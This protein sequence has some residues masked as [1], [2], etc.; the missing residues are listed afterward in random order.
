M[1]RPTPAWLLPV[2]R[3]LV[4]IAA[5]AVIAAGV[6]Y[7]RPP[8]DLTIEVGAV[9]GSYYDNAVQYRD[10]LAR[11]GINLHIVSNN[12]TLDIVKDVADPAVPI[13]VGFIAE[14]VTALRGADVSTLSIV[15]LQPLFVF[16][17]AELGRRTILDDLRGR[18]IV[19]LPIG[20]ATANAALRVFQLLDVTQENTSFT[21]LPLA[22]AVRELRAGK[23]DAGAFMLSPD[24]KLIREMAADSGLTLMPF[25]EVRAIANQL[26]F[27]RPVVLPR[28]IYN[29]ADG[30]P[31][32]DT[33]LLAAS[34]GLVAHNG[35]H[36]WI[37]YSLLDAVGKTHRG[38]TLVSEAGDFPT[39]S[40]SQLEVDP[41]AVQWYKN[42]LPWVWR[43]LP[44]EVASFV[45]RYEPGLLGT[46]VFGALVITGVFLAEIA[47]LLVGLLGWIGRGG[48]RR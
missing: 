2:L 1:T 10:Y 27:L 29:I 48:G 25:G 28:G 23:F 24:N 21:F 35:L 5:A 41:I 16:A 22:D 38:A 31:P 14:D 18:R 7:A 39:I 9:G 40:G 33:P 11:R 17:S 3:L 32:N 36:P 4:F 37:I 30:I 26:P 15:Q 46:L 19:T 47:N 43:A 6:W 42:G 13:D 20:S 45:I 8:H 44:P 34:V 12:N